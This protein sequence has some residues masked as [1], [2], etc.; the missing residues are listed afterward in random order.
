MNFIRVTP[1]AGRQRVV[2]LDPK[3]GSNNDDD[4]DDDD[5]NNNKDMSGA[6]FVDSNRWPK[7]DRSAGLAVWRMASLRYSFH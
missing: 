5:G 2:C 7:Y 6:A 4:D 3:R 1:V